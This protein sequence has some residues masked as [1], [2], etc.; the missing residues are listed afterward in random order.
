M[1]HYRTVTAS[2]SQSGPCLLGSQFG[3]DGLGKIDHALVQYQVIAKTYL[4][5][6]IQS[7]S[8]TER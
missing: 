4:E 3:V 7:I 2:M 1:D 5:Y 8:F 6:P